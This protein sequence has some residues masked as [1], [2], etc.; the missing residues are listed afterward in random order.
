MPTR[1]PA[2]GE[3]RGVSFNPAFAWLEESYRQR[4]RWIITLKVDPALD[5]LR[6]DPRFEE[7]KG[8]AIF[9]AEP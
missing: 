2:A 3:K 9:P 4:E 7:L 6:T 5:I 1:M 8:R